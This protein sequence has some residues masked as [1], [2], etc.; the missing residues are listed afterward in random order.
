VF[1]PI[2]ITQLESHPIFMNQSR[3]KQKPA[4]VHIL[5]TLERL[6]CEGNGASV[7]KTARACGIG[8][9]TVVLYTKRVIAAILDMEKEFVYWPSKAQCK[10]ISEQIAK[11]SGFRGCVGI[12][13][14]THINFAQRPSINPEC[15]WTRKFRYSINAQ[16]VCDDQRNILFYQV[17]CSLF[18]FI[19]LLNLLHLSQVGWPGSVFDNTCFRQSNLFQNHQRYFSDGEYL[20]GD[21]AYQI[22]P[23]M[24]IPYKGAQLEDDKRNMAFNLIFSRE[25]VV[26]EHVMGL[27]KTRWMSLRAIRTQYNEKKDLVYINQWI[28]TVFIL[29]NLC[30][31]MNDVWHVNFE[32]EPE[33]TEPYIR[34]TNVCLY[35]WRERIKEEVLA[36]NNDM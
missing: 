2:Y 19:H 9:G 35:E 28:V 6:G 18:V 11:R 32:Q 33:S 34:S 8:A 23:Q 7:G 10:G 17:I 25:R 31:Y 20:F 30:L 24:L 1:V 16:V 14:G 26:V 27:L 4:W 13:D 22:S 12:I 15:Y 29:H 3:C 5:V 36:F 21:S